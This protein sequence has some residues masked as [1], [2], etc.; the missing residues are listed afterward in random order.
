MVHNGEKKLRARRRTAPKP[1]RQGAYWLVFVLLLGGLAG[2]CFFG[3]RARQ[4]RQE[5]VLP[6]QQVSVTMIQQAA[7]VPPGLQV[8][9][10]AQK[11]D[12]TEGAPQ[13]L[14][15]HTHTTEAY[16]PTKKN[17]YVEDGG[18]WRTHD[19]TRNIVRVGESLARILREE[20]GYAVIHDTTDHEPPKL[21]SAYSRS[22]ET[23][24]AYR[25]KYPSL[26][27]FID[28]HRDAYGASGGEEDDAVVNGEHMARLMFVVGTGKGATGTGFG[29]MPDFNSNYALADSVTERLRRVNPELVREIRVKTGRYNQHVSDQCLLVEVGHNRNTLEEALAAIPYLAA[30]IASAVD[31]NGSAQTIHQGNDSPFVPKN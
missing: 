23:M 16:T 12:P 27:V 30:A 19:N 18:E 22:E 20:Y 25:E 8:E 4:N 3:W 13:I 17:S 29:E 28:V 15:Y 5:D 6:A 21:S 31:G 24:K 1:I 9:R 2:V 14:I 26:T 7:S 11:A 10:V